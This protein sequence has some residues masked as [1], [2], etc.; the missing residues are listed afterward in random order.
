MMKIYFEIFS[1]VLF[2]A[3][4]YHSIKN[5][6]KL[7]MNFFLPIFIFTFIAEE[8]SVSF[9]HGFEYPDYFLYILNI[10]LGIILGWCS[11]V[12]L[13]FQFS[14]KIQI[15]SPTTFKISFY[16]ALVG[17]GFDFVLEPLAKIYNFWIW[18]RPNIYFDA[19]VENFI[20]W[21]LIIFI[22]INF[23][24]FIKN[25]IKD[26]RNKFLL[27]LVSVPTGL[28]ILALIIIFWKQAIKFISHTLF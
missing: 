7:A 4:L 18:N 20:S 3:C 21:F 12:Y 5:E 23:Y 15:N 26:N 1:Y 2:V 10:P 9:F 6:K 17:L 28:I 27:S 22:Y 11:I 16:S 25:N 13:S 24:L 19:P 8:L 14:K